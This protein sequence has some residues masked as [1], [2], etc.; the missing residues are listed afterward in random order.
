MEQESTLMY[1]CKIKKSKQLR[2]YTEK[3]IMMMINIMVIFSLIVFV[4]NSLR[5][6]LS[7]EKQ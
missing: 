5:D 2:E 4:M 3:T 1:I 6:E 7:T